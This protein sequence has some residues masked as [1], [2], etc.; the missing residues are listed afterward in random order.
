[1]RFRLRNVLAVLVG[2]LLV[3]ATPGT[4][5]AMG[6][7]VEIGGTDAHANN[8]PSDQTSFALGLIMDNTFRAAL[9]DFTLWADVQIPLKV[10][11]AD[12]SVGDATSY[13]PIDLGLRLGLALP[14]EPYIGI[15]IGGLFHTGSGP[16]VSVPGAIFTLGGDLGAD[17]VLGPL[18][19]GLELRGMNLQNAPAF[20]DTWVYQLL[21]AARISF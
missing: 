3:A 21:A 5:R 11:L 10:P 16:A 9:I 2:S 1:M 8:G 14:I 7:G 17:L 4:A 13:F 12:P 15:L 18:R 6:V 19:L 20:P